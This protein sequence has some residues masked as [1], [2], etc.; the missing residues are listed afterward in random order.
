MVL[1]K[2][3]SKG[4]FVALLAILH[5]TGQLCPAVEQLN[6]LVRYVGSSA[7]EPCHE[8]EYKAF[9][10]Y[11]KKNSSFESILRLRRELTDEE[12]RDCCFC[13]TTGYGKP[14]GFI[15]EEATP[16]L[17]NAGCEVCHGPGQLHVKT[18]NTEDIKEEL[19]RAIKYYR[20]L[21]RSDA[22]NVQ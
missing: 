16:H 9:T 14:G 12:V 10:S 11:A 4:L 21:D 13:H 18:Q 17:K 3:S 5:T 19:T 6:S 2:C 1:R 8:K 20:E 7:C 15:S 22:A